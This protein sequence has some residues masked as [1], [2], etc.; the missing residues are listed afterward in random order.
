MN[1][2]DE[3][4]VVKDLDEF[5]KSARTLIYNNFGDWDKSEDD[6]V[7]SMITK[8]EDEAEFN[9]LLTQEESSVIVKNTLKKQR[10]KNTNAIRYLVCDSLF[11]EILNQLNDR[12]VSNT[13]G[14]LVQK[15]LVES[16]YDDEVDDFVFWVKDEIQK[17]ET[18]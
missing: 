1:T 8:P 17:P 11:Y 4:F 3:W 14:S 7:D 12:M 15:G 10:N 16:A 13:I 6:I 9:Q 18:D 5:V 2:D